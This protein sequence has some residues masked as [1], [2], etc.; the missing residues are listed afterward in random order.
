MA[1]RSCWS[2]FPP[3]TLSAATHD[4]RHHQADELY[5]ADAGDHAQ[6]W[7]CINQPVAQSRVGGAHGDLECRYGREIVV[8]GDLE[9]WLPGD[10]AFDG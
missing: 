4:R 9:R 2:R 3:I 7:L 8:L 1:S 6:R 5:A 10:G